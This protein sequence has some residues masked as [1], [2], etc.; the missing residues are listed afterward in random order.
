MKTLITLLLVALFISQSHAND[1]EIATRVQSV[2][3]YHSGALV[4]RTASVN[5]NSGVTELTV[6]NISSKIVLNTLKIG[7]KEV[8]VLNKS[9]IKK[10][11]KEQY[12]QL[13]DRKEA[14]TKQIN[15][16]EAKFNEVGFVSKVE[17]LERMTAFYSKE[18]VKLKKE[19]REV[20]NDI[21]QANS[22]E[23]IKL[24]NENAAILKLVVSVESDLKEPLRIQ[25]VCGGIGWSPSYDVIV[26]NASKN[27]IE[28][29]YLAKVMSQTG[30][31]WENVEIQLSSSFPLDSPTELPRPK[32]SWVLE[33][34]RFN[35]KRRAQGNDDNANEQ[36]IDKLEGVSYQEINI[37]SFLKMR[38]LKEKYSLKSNSTVFS[39]PIQSVSLPANFYYYGFPT[40]DSEV[41]LVA[42]VTGWDTLGFIDGVANVTFGNN[43]IGKSIIKFSEAKD[44]LL[45]P[46]GKD[47]SVY[48]KR[49]EIPNQK[50]FSSSSN[51]KKKETTLAY[52]YELKNNNS[53][54]I[55][56]ELV[57][58]VPISQTKAA[59]VIIQKSSNATINRP[60]GEISWLLSLGPGQ[61]IS[62][63][64]IF[65]VE[66]DSNYDYFDGKSK[67]KFRTIAA[68]SF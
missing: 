3:I 59:E 53:F 2:T 64:L 11:S 39:F 27:S 20:E 54:P 22:I 4:Y 24:D 34:A 9:L 40:Y 55:R 62:K 21:L 18:I 46:V 8:T 56:F 36:R 41:Y 51:G 7:N 49:L 12:S 61:S 42:Q 44:T 60:T 30:E 15:L 43:D 68:P 67:A 1:L 52:S 37:P 13:I 48:L 63:E 23:S 14:I 10:L 25:Y 38:K 32:E 65:T 29:K 28:L 35:D 5:L 58:Q 66:T 50:Y 19:L 16:I 6:K 57:D 33:N 31:D 26:E 47:N 17:D 45:L